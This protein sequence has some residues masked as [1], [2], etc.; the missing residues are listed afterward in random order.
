M[1]FVFS[2]LSNVLKIW[3][4]YCQLYHIDMCI[5]HQHN[6]SIKDSYFDC[7]C[8]NLILLSE[9]LIIQDCNTETTTGSQH[10]NYFVRSDVIGQRVL[11]LY[12]SENITP[13]GCCKEDVTSLL[14]HLSYIFFALSHQH[15]NQPKNVFFWYSNVLEK[16]GMY[17]TFLHF[18]CHSRIYTG[19]RF[20][21]NYACSCLII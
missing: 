3:P 2:F 5:Y 17:H 4:G 15:S 19:H 21:H 20:G 9:K 12:G 7:F 6:N 11:G 16:T 1:W 8:F 13:M 14:T 10:F 18:I